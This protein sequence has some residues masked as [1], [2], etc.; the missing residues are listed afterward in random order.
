VEEGFLVAVEVGCHISALVREGLA[1]EGS[2]EGFP[3][4]TDIEQTGPGASGRFGCIDQRL[5]SLV[6]MYGVRRH[7]RPW[8]WE[9]KEL[10]MNVEME[11]DAADSCVLRLR[12]I[13][14]G[15]ENVDQI[16]ATHAYCITAFFA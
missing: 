15:C 2:E 16:A 9:A 4:D 8:R 10:Y 1:W 14:H 12:F 5:K 3:F 6:E 11:G 7:A 13:I